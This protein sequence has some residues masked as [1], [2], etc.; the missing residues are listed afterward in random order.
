MVILRNLEFDMNF[1][2]KTI[3]CKNVWNMPLQ[4]KLTWKSYL[5]PLMPSTETLS[6]TPSPHVENYL[7]NWILDESFPFLLASLD[8]Q[9]LLQAVG[10]QKLSDCPYFLVL[11]LALSLALAP[12]IRYLVELSLPNIFYHLPTS[13]VQNSHPWQRRAVQKW[14]HYH[15]VS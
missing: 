14:M 4:M 15:Q 10:T 13:R 12:H 11:V 5:Q 6:T 2:I 3:K 7:L 8:T 1:D 9:T